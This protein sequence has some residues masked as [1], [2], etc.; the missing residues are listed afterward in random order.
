MKIR[1]WAVALVL[2]SGSSAAFADD[3]GR[4]WLTLGL[5]LIYGHVEALD[6]AQAHW[7]AAGMVIFSFAVLMSL[8]LLKRAGSIIR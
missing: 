1:F 4:T 5:N 7:L 6:Y 3:G 2:M 8:G